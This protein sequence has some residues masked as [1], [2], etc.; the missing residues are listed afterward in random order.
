MFT[1]MQMNF[2]FT[3]HRFHVRITALSDVRKRILRVEAGIQCAQKPQK[4]EE[5]L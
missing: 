3:N 1:Y 2:K 5:K 4:Y